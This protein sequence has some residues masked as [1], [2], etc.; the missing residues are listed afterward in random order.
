MKLIEAQIPAQFMGRDAAATFAL[1]VRQ[2][3]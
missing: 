3:A 1:R 2:T